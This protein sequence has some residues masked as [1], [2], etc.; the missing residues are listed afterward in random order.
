M[1]F[2]NPTYLIITIL[3]FNIISCNT[4]SSQCYA[5]YFCGG[6]TNVN[7]AVF[8]YLTHFDSNVASVKPFYLNFQAIF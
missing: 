4:M 5:D 3:Y 7:G 2:S 8:R 6:V 1:I